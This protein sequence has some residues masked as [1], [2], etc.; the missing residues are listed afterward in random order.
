MI[1]REQLE[2]GTLYITPRSPFARRVRVAFLENE[3]AFRE[4]VLDLIKNPHPEYLKI[5]PLKKVPALRLSTGELVVDSNQILHVLYQSVKSPFAAQDGDLLTCSLW[6]GI[7]TGLCER[8]IEYFF[9]MNRRESHRDR[10]VIDEVN[11]AIRSSL[12]LF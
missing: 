3:I 11:E 12:N 8:A 6:S 9:E 1:R 10:G 4:V 5:N 7:G 2:N